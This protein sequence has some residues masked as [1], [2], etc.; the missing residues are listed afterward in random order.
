[1][2]LVEKKIE[3]DFRDLLEKLRQIEER[4]YRFRCVE[5]WP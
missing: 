2:G 1:M 4:I 3:I 5:A